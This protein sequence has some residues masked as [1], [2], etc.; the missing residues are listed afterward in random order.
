MTLLMRVRP[1]GFA[2]NDLRKKSQA[3]FFGWL[4]DCVQHD[5]KLL[6]KL[7]VVVER[8]SRAK[9]DALSPDHSSVMLQTREKLAS[10]DAEMRQALAIAWLSVQDEE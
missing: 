7:D 2:E 10:L 6:A 4:R 1:L 3:W 9:L 8:T 5:E